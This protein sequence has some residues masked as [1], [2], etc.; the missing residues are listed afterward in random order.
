MVVSLFDMHTCISFNW[1][2]L[3]LC[4][5]CSIS[6]MVA[7]WQC[8]LRKNCFDPIRFNSIQCNSINLFKCEIFSTIASTLHTCIYVN[9]FWWFSWLFISWQYSF[10]LAAA[11]QHPSISARMLSISS[12][13]PDGDFKF[14][15]GFRTLFSPCCSIPA[16]VVASNSDLSLTATN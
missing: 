12:S 10:Y 13:W 6:Q 9:W 8:L 3:P 15:T 2:S 1:C 4:M 11:C 16:N 14:N 5:G 7:H